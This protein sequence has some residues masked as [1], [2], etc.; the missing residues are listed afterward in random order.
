MMLIP[1]FA[2]VITRIITKEGFKKMML[3]PYFRGNIKWYSIAYFAPPFI[4][5]FGALV[6]FLIYRSDFS[7]LESVCAKQEQVLSLHEYV[8]MLSAL[9]PL[10][11]IVN[12]VMGILQCFGEELGWRGYLLPKIG[13]YLSPLKA[14]VVTGVIWGLWHAPIIAMGYNYGPDHPI[15]GILA[16]TVFCTVLGIISGFLTYKVRSIWPAVLFHASIN[17]MD[18]WSAST[19]FMSH[20]SN[21]FIGP[22]LLGIIGGMGF[23]IW[24]V[25]PIVIMR[26]WKNNTLIER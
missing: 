6:Y 12:P 1:A 25:V 8:K 23:I 3:R 14:S 10:A 16:M 7:P 11:I 2:S 13:E 21:P 17:G 4:A 19:L 18:T 9:I 22:D 26:K 24:A 20:T 5:Y 15:A